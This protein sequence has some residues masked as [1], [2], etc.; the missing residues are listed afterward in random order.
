MSGR[1][2]HPRF[3][4]THAWEGA[5]RILRDVIVHRE[6]DGRLL[7]LGH[8]PGVAGEQ[9]DLELAGA[10]ESVALRVQVVGSRPVVCDGSVRHWVR[11][12]ILEAA[13]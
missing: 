7:A 10:G 3:A 1:R 5:V 4:P 2:R 6:P 8:M 9:L 11:L 13:Q 12:E